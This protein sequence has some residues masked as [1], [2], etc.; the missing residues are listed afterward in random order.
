[1]ENVY[2]QIRCEGNKL[3][4]CQEF[5]FLCVRIFGK[6]ARNKSC[7]KQR[8]RGRHSS[9]H[10]KTHYSSNITWLQSVN[11]EPVLNSYLVHSE[12]LV[13]HIV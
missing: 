12:S 4:F 2:G 7:S 11:K 10:N 1:M 13:E 6:A 5:F 8:G 3:W 9:K